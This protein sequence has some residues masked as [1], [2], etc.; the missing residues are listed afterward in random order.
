VGGTA[1]DHGD[2][3]VTDTNGN[4]YVTGNFQGSNVDFDPGAS[5]SFQLSANGT[6]G[7]ILKL[8]SSGNFIW[9]IKFG[10][11]GEVNSNSIVTQNGMIYPS[12][13]F[14][15]TIATGI[16]T[17]SGRNDQDIFISKYNW[18]GNLI[19]IKGI[20]NA[21]E[22]HLTGTI[23]DSKGN[24]YLTGSFNASSDFNPGVGVYNLPSSGGKDIFISKLDT[25]GSLVWAKK[26]GGT[27][28]DIPYSITIDRSNDIIVTGTSDGTGTGKGMLQFQSGEE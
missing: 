10:Q 25:G 6:D 8:T 16:A 22:E 19:W 28:D 17:V 4:I 9:A 14:Y 27:Y 2:A 20:G 3:L 13:I 21:S 26:I 11:S 24:I 15:G 7:F 1:T 12:G 23:T 18:L 5:S